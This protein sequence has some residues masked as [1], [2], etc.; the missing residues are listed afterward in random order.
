MAG[1]VDRGAN[2]SCG[3]LMCDHSRLVMLGQ[4]RA[5]S[6]LFHCPDTCTM[7][8]RLMLAALQHCQ[9]R[10]EAGPDS[11]LCWDRM[12]SMLC[13]VMRVACHRMCSR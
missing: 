13:M 1:H 3:A 2:Q 8:S 4:L 9:K 7:G 12:A 6:T 5:H 10:S 11:R